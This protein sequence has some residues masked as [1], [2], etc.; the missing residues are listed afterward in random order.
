MANS[1]SKFAAL[2]LLVLTQPAAPAVPETNAAP[3][4]SPVF[5]VYYDTLRLNAQKAYLADTNQFTTAARLGRTCFDA[6]E[7]ATN[8]AQ[9]A[10]FAL[11]GIAASQQAIDLK[12]N[13]A[14]GYY[15]LGLNQ[16]QLARTKSL[17][18]IKLVTTMTAA[19]QRARELD[20]KIDFAG[21]DRCLGLLYRDAPGWPISVG[22]KRLAR[23]YLVK[24][25]EVAPAF[26][27]NPLNLI[28]ALVMW[29]ETKAATDKIPALQAVMT[30]ART[31]LVG[32]P[33]AAS[34][35]DWSNRLQ[36]LPPVP[37]K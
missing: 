1:I 25:N 18:A 7:F 14:A 12:T 3:A 5:L 36:R 27:E 24:A 6:G 37:K 9:R 10:A 26:P 4:P 21:P 33:W 8:S 29:G 17:G 28:E 34:W 20:P 22:N 15:Y 11:E 23:Q 16:G 32:E 30:K 13:E 35:Q 2:F 31:N 19:F